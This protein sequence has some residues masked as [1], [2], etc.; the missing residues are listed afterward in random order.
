LTRT[1][2]SLLEEQWDRHAAVY[3]LVYG[4][5]ERGRLELELR[6]LEFAFDSLARRPIVDVLDLTAGTGLQAVALAGLGYKV[7]ASDISAEM[8]AR[9][10]KRAT[11]ADVELAGIVH[12]PATQIDEREQFDA[13][14]SC[15]FGLSHVLTESEMDHVFTGAHRALRPGGLLIFDTINLLEDA[16]IASPRSERSGVRDSVRFRS[17]M[18][19]R[20][21]TWSSLVHFSEQ[22]EVVDVHGNK[23]RHRAEF[24]VRGWARSEIR[25]LLA[26]AG[27]QDIRQFRGYDDQGR[28]DDERVFK[29]VF[30]C[31]K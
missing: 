23:Q 29:L 10:S 24:T 31:R 7:T 26:A 12:R 27:F 13:C 6:F 22:T 14:V 25:Q 3:D 11:A 8:L 18:E 16:L 9:C 5:T 19:S 17:V 21:D 20:Y 28:S 4:E 30:A 2:I 1:D 15:F